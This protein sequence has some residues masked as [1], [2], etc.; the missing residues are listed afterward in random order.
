MIQILCLKVTDLKLLLLLACT[1]C[2][3]KCIFTFVLNVWSNVI[4][5]RI[6]I[7][8]RIFKISQDFPRC[9]LT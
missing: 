6:Q 1:V 8:C 3:L 9:S 4:V 2:F 7:K 5:K